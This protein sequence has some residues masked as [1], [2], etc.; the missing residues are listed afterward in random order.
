VT[1]DRRHLLLRSAALAPIALLTSGS[2]RPALTSPSGLPAGPSVDELTVSVLSHGAVGDGRADDTAALRSAV[3][4]VLAGRRDDG[5]VT[6]TLVLPA[7]IYR[8]TEPDALLS[9]PHSDSADQVRGL[10]IRGV[11]KRSTEI[12]F[13]VKA[14]ASD[15]P[16]ANN[17]MTAA[18]RLRG[19]RISGLSFRSENPHLN[20]LYCWSRDTADSAKPTYG[21]GANQD[22][23]LEDVEWRGSWN[24]VIGL[25]GTK[26]SNLNSEWT[27]YNCHASNSASFTDA[28]LHSGMSPQFEQ[29][30]QFLNFWFYACKFEY[31]AGTLLRLAKGGF[32]TVNGGSFIAGIQD[33]RPAAFFVMPQGDH[34]A[35]VQNLVVTGTR[36]ELRHDRVQ[37]MDCGWSGPSAH[38]TFQNVSDG[39]SSFRDWAGNTRTVTLRPKDGQLPTVKFLNSELMG[40]HQV[41]GASAGSGKVVYDGC[42]FSNAKAGGVGP[43]GFLRHEGDAPSYRFVDCY[44]V[45]DSTG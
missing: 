17:L 8:V 29:Q 12:F 6:R 21:A 13:D 14:G 20:W 9:S 39:S 15:D 35:S 19:L 33:Q 7:G 38:L 25:D 1:I 36:F 31:A 37:L 42:N 5:Q 34:L 26:E 43:D 32:V 24:R 2:A 23:V 28:F 30:D 3:K 41:Q 44:G 10:T 18:N 45:P 22:F 27:F 16:F 40:Y 11:G 4:E